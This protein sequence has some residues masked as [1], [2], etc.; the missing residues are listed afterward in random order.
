MQSIR[1][2]SL[3][4]LVAALF[5][6]GAAATAALR[7]LPAELAERASLVGE[8]EV[9]SIESAWSEDGK[10]IFSRVRLRL[11]EAWKGEGGEVEIVVPGG[12]VG[13]LG[14]IVQGMPAFREGE[15]VVVFLDRPAPG[16]SFRVVGLAQGKFTVAELPAEGR[17]LFPNLEGLKLIDPR[18]GLEAPPVLEGPIRLDAFRRQL[19][20]EEAR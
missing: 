20:P 16:P 15:R 2:F 5:P 6:A 11:E 9:L 18:T 10:R 1:W 8:G 7:L 4:G 12:E 14:Q 3:L 19:F 13:E 17:Y